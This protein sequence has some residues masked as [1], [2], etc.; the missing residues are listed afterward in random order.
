MYSSNMISALIMSC[1]E[2]APVEM[3]DARL[4]MPP[5][6]DIKCL[7]LVG[8]CVLYSSLGSYFHDPC[9]GRRWR[10]TPTQI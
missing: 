9:A 10:R 1:P 2:R 3:M 7:F 6:G 4:D 8:E 5:G